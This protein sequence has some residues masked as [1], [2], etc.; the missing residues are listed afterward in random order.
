[1]LYTTTD[2]PTSELEEMDSYI[3]RCRIGEINASRGGGR[4][5]KG[6]IGNTPLL[7]LEHMIAG[8]DSRLFLKLKNGIESPPTLDKSPKGAH[9]IEPLRVVHSTVG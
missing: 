8:A 3:A 2:N 1:M 5:L 4:N 6:R 7:R 9:R